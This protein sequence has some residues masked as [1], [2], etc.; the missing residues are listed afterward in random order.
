[1]GLLDGRMGGR[2]SRALVWGAEEKE[3][4]VLV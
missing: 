3:W 1:M 4:G 2:M